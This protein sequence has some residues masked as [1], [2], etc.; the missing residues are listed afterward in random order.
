MII[1]VG[2]DEIKR[3][4]TEGTAKMSETISG[5]GTVEVRIKIDGSVEGYKSMNFDGDNPVLDFD[6]TVR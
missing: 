1:I 2:N 5:K 3:T 6:I 4:L